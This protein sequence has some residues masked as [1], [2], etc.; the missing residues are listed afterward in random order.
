[1][2][3]EAWKV[4]AIVSAPCTTYGIVGQPIMRICIGPTKFSC[5]ADLVDWLVRASVLAVLD[6]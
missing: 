2:V 4:G 1:M 3:S 6:D 5:A